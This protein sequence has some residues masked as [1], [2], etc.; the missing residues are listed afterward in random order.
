MSD[1]R[2]Q[3][4]NNSGVSN[5]WEMQME[6]WR[7]TWCPMPFEVDTWLRRPAK[8]R[9]PFPLLVS[10]SLGRRTCTAHGNVSR[11]AIGCLDGD[12]LT[13]LLG[14]Y[15]SKLPRPINKVRVSDRKGWFGFWVFETHGF[16]VLCEQRIKRIMCPKFLPRSEGQ[17]ISQFKLWIG[18]DGLAELKAACSV[19]IWPDCCIVIL[20]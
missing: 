11:L 1:T 17:P 2:R 7:E 5:E 19:W 10:S 13:K 8:R 4:Y 3:V 12:L 14:V 20:E 16:T 18:S 9:R 6:I 15:R